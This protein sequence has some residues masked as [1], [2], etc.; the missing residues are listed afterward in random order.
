MS[1]SCPA[2]TETSWFSSRVLWSTL[3]SCFDPLLKD[4][5][6]YSAV[7]DR[8]MK[9]IW[10]L[11]T[12]M[13]R[14]WVGAVFSCAGRTQ[15]ARVTQTACKVILKQTPMYYI[16]TCQ[17]FCWLHSRCVRFGVRV[18]WKE[19]LDKNRGVRWKATRRFQ[20]IIGWGK[21]ISYR[22]WSNEVSI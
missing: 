17:K 10:V 13:S 11:R 16:S 20:N 7:S 8:Q 15:G 3:V 18:D 9:R 19:K 1:N 22:D 21:P 6:H 4:Y 5:I 14:F 12:K 2:A